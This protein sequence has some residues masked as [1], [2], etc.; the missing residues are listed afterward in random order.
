[1]KEI[2]LREGR[3]EAERKMFLEKSI[4]AKQYKIQTGE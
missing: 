4:P 1:M 2:I 3:T